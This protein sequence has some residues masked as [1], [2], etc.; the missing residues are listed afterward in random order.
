MSDNQ[1]PYRAIALT[2]GIVAQLSGSTIVG[3]FAGRWLDARLSTAPIFLIIGLFIG[4]AAGVYGTISLVK[5]Y[6]GDS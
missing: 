5:K 4:L 6:T 1:N 3:I 2:S